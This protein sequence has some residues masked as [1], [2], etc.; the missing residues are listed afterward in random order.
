MKTKNLFIFSL[1]LA[2][3]CTAIRT[4]TILYA[5]EGTTGF[6]I[7]RLS[8]LGIFLSIA[9][10]LLTVTAFIFAF[11][12]DKKPSVNFKLN[13]LSGTLSIICGII[14]LL[15]PL[16]Y[17]AP[18]LIGWQNNLTLFFAFLSGL[19]FALYGIS[20]FI[21]IK[22]PPLSCVVPMFYFLMRLVL[23]FTSFSSSAL[24]AE[25]VF[26]LS[27]RCALLVFMLMFLRICAGFTSKR[28]LKFFL[29]VSVTTFILTFVSVISRLIVH[30]SLG[31]AFIHG[32]IPV[33][34]DGIA[35]CLFILPI[36]YNILKKER[37]ET[38]NE[39]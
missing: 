28:T 17:K 20:A 25:H 5:T 16:L 35:L 36:T 18:S 9:V 33:D 34:Y 37:E 13:P 3:I 26:S 6:F 19:W 14:T 7:A 24:V 2:V 11:F 30:F 4:A 39:F 1:C 38:E 27:Y 15:Y 23:V 32:D 8:G 21:N 29:P 22:I 10:F 31:D 12:A